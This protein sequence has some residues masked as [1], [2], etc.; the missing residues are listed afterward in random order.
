[1]AFRHQRF[2]ATE[3]N[4][5]SEEHRAR[6]L[7]QAMWIPDLFMRRV[8]ENKPW[9][10]FCPNEAPGLFDVYGDEFDR[11][12]EKYEK[13]G[14]ARETMPAR[15]LWQEI[16]V[17]QIET[18]GPYML[19]KDTVNKRSNYQH[20]GTIRSSNL[21]SEIV[22]YSSADEIAVCNLASIRLPMFVSGDGFDFEKLLEVTKVATRNLNKI[23]DLNH[24]PVEQCRRSNLRHRPLGIGVQGLADTFI[25]MRIPYE[26]KKGRELNRDIFETI[27]F[28][29]YGQS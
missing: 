10:L 19:Y 15:D 7:F 17:A 9:S 13:E 11:L 4:T 6:D 20:I 8:E 21:C 29:P 18:G 16:L 26:S 14:R 27:Y 24:Y 3:E 5:G 23:I 2:L 25:L 28:G 22:E 1:M 12:Y